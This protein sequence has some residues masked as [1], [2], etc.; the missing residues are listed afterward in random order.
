MSFL[1]KVVVIT[2]AGGGIGS[3]TAVHFAKLGA[4][5]SL[6][7]IDE[8][9]LKKTVEICEKLSKTA[10]FKIKVDISNDEAVKSATE[11]TIKQYGRIDVLVN[12]VGV[13]GR[14]TNEC[15]ILDSKLLECFDQIIA[16]NLRAT[17]AVIHYAAPALI[18]AKGSVINISSIA[19][20]QTVSN[21]PYSVSKA[22]LNHFTRCV[23]LELAPKGVRVNAVLPGPVNTDML[24]R[25]GYDKEQSNALYKK[26]AREAPLGHVV[27]AEKVAEV[28]VYLASDKATSITGVMYA[29]DAGALLTSITPLKASQ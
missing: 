14:L 16:I 27:S 5:L 13:F 1:N 7:D 11:R 22:S 2:G 18:E 20:V 29:V 12:C 3:A 19:A 25:S 8:D 23:A 17:I 6:F 28:V 26:L 10:V 9:N 15:N 21:V 4:R 24:L